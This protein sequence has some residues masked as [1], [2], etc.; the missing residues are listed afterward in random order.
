MICETV[1]RMIT[2]LFLSIA[3]LL[4]NFFQDFIIEWEKMH[5]AMGNKALA[6]FLLLDCCYSISMLIEIQDVVSKP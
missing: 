4:E 2:T 3:I 5:N 6:T 1:V